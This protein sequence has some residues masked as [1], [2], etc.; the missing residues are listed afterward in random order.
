MAAKIL[1]KRA[2]DT[3]TIVRHTC[4]TVLPNHPER[5][6]VTLAVNEAPSTAELVQAE[7]SQFSKKCIKNSS[8]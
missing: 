8:K 7:L 1:K 5:L 3:Q 6:A 4:K 2:S